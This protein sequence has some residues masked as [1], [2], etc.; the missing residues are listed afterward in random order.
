MCPSDLPAFVNDVVGDSALAGSVWGV[1]VM[2]TSN[3]TVLAEL[4]A[5]QFFVPASN[6]KLLTT[7]AALIELS[8]EFTISTPVSLCDNGM[9]TSIVCIA[10]QGD[11]TMV[12]DDLAALAA[13]ISQ[14]VDGGQ[15]ILQAD[16]T[17]MQGFPTAWEWQDLMDTDGALPV[18][19]VVDENYLSF[20]VAPASDVG[21]TPT[22]TNNATT[23]FPTVNDA[24]TVSGNPSTPLSVSYALDDS[25]TVVVSGEITLGSAAQTFILPALGPTRNF[26]SLLASYLRTTNNVTDLTTGSCSAGA[27]P[28]SLQ[29]PVQTHAPLQSCQPLTT[30][31]SLPFS[32]SMDWCLKQSDNLY[33]ELFLRQL[34]L[35][36]AGSAAYDTSI[37]TVKKV[38]GARLP[39]VNSSLFYQADGSGLSRHNLVSPRSLVQTLTAMAATDEAANYLSF[40]PIA[41]V[42]GTLA[43]RYVGTPAEGILHA[44]TGSMTGVNS[45]SGWVFPRHYD[46]PIVFAILSNDAS[47]SAT[48][49]RRAID[50]IGVAL[51]ELTDECD[52]Q[53][54]DEHRPKPSRRRP[55]PP[56]RRQPGHGQAKGQGR[57]KGQKKRGH[58]D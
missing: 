54:H 56:R 21:G 11:A 7:A 26:L 48:V 37:T 53:R 31:R 44:K 46:A 36:V 3:N 6:N 35:Q 57:G 1:L 55:E 9:G 27:V 39:S 12:H 49:V 38:M 58:H 33:A 23:T 18:S 17:L 43:D 15:V 52:Q 42:D 32:A 28:R 22:V 30:L 16:D 29:P 40:L 13:T 10:G 8:S 5:D 4:N 25:R 45:L 51:A 34:G 24:T 41:G 2:E 14:T 47:A 20:V 19:F 50:R